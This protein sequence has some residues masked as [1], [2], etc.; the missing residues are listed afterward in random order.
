MSKSTPL[1]QLPQQQMQQ[2]QMPDPAE[3]D[4]LQEV[5]K[6]TG[7]YMPLPQH[8]LMQ[9]QQ[10]PQYATAMTPEKFFSAF[11]DVD[12]KTF[13]VAAALFGIASHPKVASIIAEKVPYLAGG[14]IANLAVRAVVFAAL[15]VVAIKTLKK[16]T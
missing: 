6:T 15:L 13:V 8:M 5:M 12:Y 1:N 3:Q 14:S 16:M 10:Q 9:P 7:D 2:M 4:V 11:N